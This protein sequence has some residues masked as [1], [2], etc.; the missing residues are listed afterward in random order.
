M[1]RSIV[2][3]SLLA[4]GVLLSPQVFALSAPPLT[5]HVNDYAHMLSRQTAEELEQRLSEFEQTDST[6]IVVLTIPSLEGENLEEFSIKVAEAWKV[7]WKGVDNGVILLIARDDRKVRIEVGRGLEGK[8]TDLVSGR[9]IRNNIT[10]GFRAGDFDK[11]VRDGVQAIIEVV[12]GE[13]KSDD[14]GLSQAIVRRA[15]RLSSRFFSFCLCFLCLSVR[16]RSC[17]V[18]LQG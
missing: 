17:W 6:Q 8:L 16:C 3:L 1:I 14:R 11:G 12:R 5:A 4:I 18:R 9:I 7:G 15:L 10:P 2:C 13:Y